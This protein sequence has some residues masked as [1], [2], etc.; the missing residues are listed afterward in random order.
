MK[1]TTR[2]ILLVTKSYK[3]DLKKSIL[4]HMAFGQAVKNKTKPPP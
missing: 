2:A 1:F 3:D 4:Y